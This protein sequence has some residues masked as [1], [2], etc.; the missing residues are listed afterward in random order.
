MLDAGLVA[1][2]ATREGLRS[3][4]ERLR[5]EGYRALETFTPV[6]MPDMDRLFSP[7]PTAITRI[8][9]TAAATG[10]L[11]AYGLQWL[12][13][14][15][16]Y[17]IDVGGRPPHSPPAFVPITFETGVLFTGIATFL[18]VL[19]LSG[20]PRLWRP[21]FEI[22]GF[23]RA[24]IDRWFLLVGA[25]DPRFGWQETRDHLSDLSPLRVVTLAGRPS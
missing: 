7:R 1:E 23:A 22:D 13:N 25:E 3:A 4:V 19:V 20:L 6:P 14:S 17:P 2:F 8:A 16:L 18:A 12:L 10:V 21:I 24:S 9:G 11:F 5:A 15:V